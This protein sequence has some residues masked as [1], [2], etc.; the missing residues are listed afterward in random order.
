GGVGG[1]G[2]ASDGRLGAVEV[3]VEGGRVVVLEGGLRDSGQAGDGGGAELQ[4]AAHSRA[5]AAFVV[6]RAA[7]GTALGGVAGH[8]RPVQFDGAADGAQPAA[9]P[10]AAVA[11]P[12]AIA[13]AVSALGGVAGQGEA[14]Q[15]NHPA[16]GPQA[17]RAPAAPG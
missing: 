2:G 12:V 9:E 11:A 5:G 4:A 6:L 17:G 10:D 7:A 13:A 14:A 15:P 1:R 8:G 3:R 16:A